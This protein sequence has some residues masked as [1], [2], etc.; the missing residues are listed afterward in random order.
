MEPP[1][2]WFDRDCKLWY[3]LSSVSELSPS[4]RYGLSQGRGRWATNPPPGRPHL[5]YIH[6]PHTEFVVGCGWSLYE[7]GVLASC[8]WDSRLN[9]FRPLNWKLVKLLSFSVFVSRPTCH[10]MRSLRIFSLHRYNRCTISHLL[11]TANQASHSHTSIQRWSDRS[12]WIF[13]KQ[14][15]LLVGHYMPLLYGSRLFFWPTIYQ[16][17]ICI[18]IKIFRYWNLVLAPDYLGSCWHLNILV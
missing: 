8:G 7:V 15:R 10:K 11:H 9:V 14:K 2:S 17:W 12:F 4:L 13:R 6:D 1:S 16:N 3:E 18:T 5:V